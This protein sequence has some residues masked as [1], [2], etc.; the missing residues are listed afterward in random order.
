MLG[1][2]KN[3]K[4]KVLFYGDNT[5]S[6]MSDCSISLKCRKPLII[7]IRDIFPKTVDSIL[8]VVSIKK[9]YTRK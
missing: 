1:S 4:L 2:P 6:R 8:N 7:E 5:G 9:K 3:F